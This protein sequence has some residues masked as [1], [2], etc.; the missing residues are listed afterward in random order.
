MDDAVRE[1]WRRRDKVDR[2]LIVSLR[3]AAGL[4]ID[5]EIFSI[6]PYSDDDEDGTVMMKNDHRRSLK[7]SLKGFADKTSKSSKVYVK[8]SPHSL[9]NKK[10]AKKGYQ[11]Q[12]GNISE[13]SYQN[14]EGQHEAKSPKSSFEDQKNAH[15][16]S[17]RRDGRGILSSPSCRS[18]GN[19]KNKPLVDQDETRSNIREASVNNIS[20]ASK[21]HI[22]GSKAEGLHLKEGLKNV[23]KNETSKGTKLVIHFGAKYRNATASP[24][25][26][27]SSGHKDQDV[28]HPSGMFLLYTS[29]HLNFSFNVGKLKSFIRIIVPGFIF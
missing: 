16:K 13:E 10:Y 6:S 8:N 19:D 27:A 3:S 15:T 11:M 4:P 25:S 22:K 23:A 14:N 28:A 18:P 29:L 5:E 24:M 12:P 26:E 17:W 1:L 2:N 7:F 9:P 21:V 20:K